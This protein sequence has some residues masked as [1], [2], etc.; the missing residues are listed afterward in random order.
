MKAVTL[1]LCLAAASAFAPVPSTSTPVRETSVEAVTRGG[2]GG[3][4][5][6]AGSID[7]SQEIGALPPVGFWDPAGFLEKE[8]GKFRQYREAELKHGRVAMLAVTGYCFVHYVG[9]LG[10]T[11]LST[12]EGVKFGDVPN[13]IQALG[14]LP[15][16]GT[17]QIIL[18]CAI[19]ELKHLPE[20][21]AYIGTDEIGDY[22][23]DKVWFGRRL[24][25]A[26]LFDKKT[27]E[28]QNGRLAMLGA[29]GL[30]A[31]DLVS[32]GTP[33]EAIAL[34]SNVV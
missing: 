30:I 18:L 32:G 16:L 29:A 19:L 21:Q 24:E 13:S 2:G 33:F 26:E 25:G 7:F 28:I 27:K 3:G 20:I 9:Q 22:G 10:N 8:P 17:A 11:Y 34:K 12:S 23:T 4:A 1:A 15:P 14:V 31:Q 6:S 5:T